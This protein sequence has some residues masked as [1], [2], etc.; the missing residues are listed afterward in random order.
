MGRDYR[1]PP[2][3]VECRGND[4][5]GRQNAPAKASSAGIAL[6]R[7]SSPRKRGPRGD[8]EKRWIPACAGMSGREVRS[9]TE[10]GAGAVAHHADGVELGLL[11]GLF[12]GPFAHLVA[13]VEQ[14]DL[15]ELLE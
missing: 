3:P 12:L 7:R 6:S 2:S 13:L 8:K 9:G 4:C 14:L 5:P 1:R 11:A 10:L 15:L